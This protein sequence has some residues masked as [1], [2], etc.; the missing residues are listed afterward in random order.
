[1]HYILIQSTETQY[2]KHDTV[3]CNT[4][5]HCSTNFIIKIEDDLYSD[6]TKVFNW[7]I[8]LIAV[9]YGS[10]NKMYRSLFANIASY[11]YPLL[12]SNERDGEILS[13]T[14]EKQY[15]YTALRMTASGEHSTDIASNAWNE[16]ARW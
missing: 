2:T 11:Q 14:Y 9:V 8:K 1:M 15:E 12:N 4:L 7:N 10:R 3:Q 6:E 5:Y 13:F 16:C